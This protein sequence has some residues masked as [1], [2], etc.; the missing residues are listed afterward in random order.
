MKK[1]YKRHFQTPLDVCRYMRSL[2]PAFANTILEPTSGE[3]NIVSVLKHYTVTAPDDYF[4]LDGS[5]RFDSVVMNP[6]FS[7]SSCIMDN[8]PANYPKGMS[9]GYQILFDCMNKTS[10][11]I[12]L[13][14]W[15][16]ISDSDVRLRFIKSYGLRTITL[17]PRKTFEYAR[18]QTCILELDSSFK[19]ETEFRV[20][21]KLPKIPCDKL[22]NQLTAQL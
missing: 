17:L 4:L 20:Y 16:T 15:Y 8:A 5:L 2:I 19:G 14:P 13:M 12:A 1:G 3:G 18:I 22:K 10:S 21:D 6:P 7:S 11:V 9:T